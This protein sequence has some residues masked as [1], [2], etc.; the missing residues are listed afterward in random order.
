[1]G[2]VLGALIGYLA[3]QLNAPAKAFTGIAVLT[4]LAGSMVRFSKLQ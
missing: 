4:L 1:M 2:Y 3:L